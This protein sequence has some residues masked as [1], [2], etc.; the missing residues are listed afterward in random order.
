MIK[1]LRVFAKKILRA[2][3]SRSIY[4]KRRSSVHHCHSAEHYFA[5]KTHV[6]FDSLISLKM[7]DATF[8]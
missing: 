8:R 1:S 2:I 4:L 3:I 6:I 5:Q 7:L